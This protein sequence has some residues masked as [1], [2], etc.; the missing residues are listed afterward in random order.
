MGRA[1]CQRKRGPPLFR[2]NSTLQSSR[3]PCKFAVDTLSASLKNKRGSQK[4]RN[5]RWEPSNEQLAIHVHSLSLFESDGHVWRPQGRGATQVRAVQAAT[6]LHSPTR[7]PR[8]RPRLTSLLVTSGGQAV[9]T[10]CHWPR[11]TFK[12]LHARDQLPH[13]TPP[14]P[15]PTPHPPLL[16]KVTLSAGDGPCL[17]SLS[18]PF[19]THFIRGVGLCLTP[20]TKK[21]LDYHLKLEGSCRL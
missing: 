20:C 21:L 2:M 10:K 18:L 8:L 12:A 14:L 9:P 15:R 3:I 19:A 1:L 16:D 5:L 6:D 7:L 13:P 11:I 17:C 4:D